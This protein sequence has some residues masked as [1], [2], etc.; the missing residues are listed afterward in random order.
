MGNLT[1]NSCSCHVKWCYYMLD[2]TT[3]RKENQKPCDTTSH[4]NNV[5][6]LKEPIISQKGNSV[7]QPIQL[8][9]VVPQPQPSEPACVESGK[10]CEITTPGQCCSQ[11]CINGDQGATCF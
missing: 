2:Y 8:Q 10:H 6:I 11:T 1:I 9:K 4:G 5:P 7:P 3:E